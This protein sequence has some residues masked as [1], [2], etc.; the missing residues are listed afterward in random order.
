MHIA[1]PT[2]SSASRTARGRSLPPIG[3][4]GKVGALRAANAEALPGRR[5]HHHPRP[6]ALDLACTELPEARDLGL[7]V[8][9]LDIEVDT[10]FM[11]HGLDLADD[12]IGVHL[13]RH[14]HRVARVFDRRTTERLTPEPRCAAELRRL[15]IDDHGA[16]ATV[17]HEVCSGLEWT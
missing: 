4:A 7:D 10:A 3:V 14:V 1:A 17:V 9:G 11:R 16:E 15:A 13:Q 2:S 8:V 6:V 5:R 12:L